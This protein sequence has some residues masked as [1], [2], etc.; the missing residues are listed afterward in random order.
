MKQ[1]HWD[2][3]D[4]VNC[5]ARHLTKGSYVGNGKGWDGC[6]DQVKVLFWSIGA[7]PHQD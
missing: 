2:C 1:T 7:V 5:A 4:L 6:I 3:G